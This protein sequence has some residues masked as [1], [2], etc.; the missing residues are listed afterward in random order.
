MYNA[1]DH[2]EALISLATAALTAHNFPSP[3][4]IPIA[5]ICLLGRTNLSFAPNG[6]PHQGFKEQ[7]PSHNVFV[8]ELQSRSESIRYQAHKLAHAHR[9]EHAWERLAPPRLTVALYWRLPVLARLPSAT[10]VHSYEE[11]T[12]LVAA[13]Q[14]ASENSSSFSRQ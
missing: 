9:P 4:N 3:F 14:R 6:N 12:G 7:T 1:I 13:S 2:R 5:H 11:S 10:C 8:M